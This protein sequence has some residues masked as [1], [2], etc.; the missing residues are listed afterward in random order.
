ANHLFGSNLAYEIKVWTS[1]P[2][3][4][5]DTVNFNDSMNAT[6]SASLQ[7]ILTIDTSIAIGSGNYHSFASLASD[8]NNRGICGPVTINVAAATY[9]EQLSLSNIA[10]ASAINTITIDGGD[11]STT[12]ISHD[13]TTIRPV[14]LL[15]GTQYLTIKNLGV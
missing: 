5:A 15:D 8:L 2:N 6:L 9:F 11:S 3:A 1:S 12:V 13:A 4:V 7:G 14:I 10:G